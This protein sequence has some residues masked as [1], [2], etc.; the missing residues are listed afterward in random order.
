MQTEATINDYAIALWD[1]PAVGDR[2]PVVETKAK[3]AIVA[4]NTDGEV[5]LVLFFDLKPDCELTVT[6]R[7]AGPEAGGATK[8]GESG[9][10][11]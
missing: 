7:P 8:H 2:L 11:P 4:R 3:D 10:A 6:L 1:V 9:E 5:H